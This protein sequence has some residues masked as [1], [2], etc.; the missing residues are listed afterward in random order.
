MASL[1]LCFTSKKMKSLWCIHLALQHII[2]DNAQLLRVGGGVGLRPY[3][4]YTTV[5]TII[6]HRTWFYNP[7]LTISW[8]IHYSDPY[9]VKSNQPKQ[10]QNQSSPQNPE[11]RIWYL[12]SGNFSS[13]SVYLFFG[14][15][16]SRT[17]SETL[18]QNPL[19]Y[20]QQIMISMQNSLLQLQWPE[21]NTQNNK[22]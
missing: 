6:I 3:Q 11:L 21:I 2:L 7:L 14:H 5:Q 9:T 13:S 19:L 12:D 17:Y 10:N 4:I 20:L 15:T 8:E 1:T 22:K 18:S 16:S